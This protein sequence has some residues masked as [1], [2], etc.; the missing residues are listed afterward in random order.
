MSRKV[1]SSYDEEDYGDED[2]YA[3]NDDYDEYDAPVAAAK[4]KK[5]QM[6]PRLL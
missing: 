4:P 5:V 2:F 6:L 1:A 3:D